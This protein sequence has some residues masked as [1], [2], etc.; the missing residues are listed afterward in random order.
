MPPNL[1]LVMTYDG[2]I[3]EAAEATIR[4]LEEDL[5][6]V[7]AEETYDA[8][9]AVRRVVLIWPQEKAHAPSE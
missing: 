4:K 2:P 8:D 3:D 1:T 9:R 7:R 6:L 5:E